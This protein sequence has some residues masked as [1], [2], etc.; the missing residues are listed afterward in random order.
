[1]AKE[2]TNK[3][4]K[5]VKSTG[6]GSKKVEKNPEKKTTK[7]EVK[8]VKE[9]KVTVKEEVKAVE[10]K[11][12]KKVVIEDAV[13]VQKPKAKREFDKKEIQKIAITVLGALVFILAVFFVSNKIT[14]CDFGKFCDKVEENQKD[15]NPLLAE[16]E[17]LDDTKMKELTEITYSDYDKALKSKKETTVIYLVSDNSY[18]NQYE[19]PILKSVAYQYNLDIKYL[20]YDNLKEEEI[21]AI[22]KLDENITK[23]TPALL[24]VNNKK[25]VASQTTPA[26]T[27]GLVS[28]L[29]E[30][31]I[32]KSGE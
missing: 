13:K 21:S 14:D 2:K 27:S 26:S 7:P 3:N 19:T 24:I 1:M 11:E 16:G 15:V 8:A 10:E 17:V 4:D 5:N 20:N 22:T 18:W 12:V 30:N 29:T 25:L 9:E 31:K 23:D 28:F 32:I 6:K